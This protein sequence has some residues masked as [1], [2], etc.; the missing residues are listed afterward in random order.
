MGNVI[1]VMGTTSLEENGT[2]YAPQDA[3]SQAKRCLEI[4]ERSISPFGAH[5]ILIKPIFLSKSNEIYA[6]TKIA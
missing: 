3:Y 4:I 6:N 2:V 1:A 5:R